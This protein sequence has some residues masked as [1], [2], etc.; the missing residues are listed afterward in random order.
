M[1]V[2]ERED[3]VGLSNG[4]QLVVTGVLREGLVDE[5]RKKYR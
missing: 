1:G 4:A 3:E 5:C 2:G